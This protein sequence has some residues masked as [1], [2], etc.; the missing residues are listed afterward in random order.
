MIKMKLD[1][2]MIQN[3]D[4]EMKFNKKEMNQIISYKSDVLMDAKDKECI[5]LDLDSIIRK[6]NQIDKL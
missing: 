4:V 5:Q 1:L 6:S 3:I 2:L